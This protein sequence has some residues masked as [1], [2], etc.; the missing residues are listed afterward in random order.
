MH[1][2]RL[3]PLHVVKFTPPVPYSGNVAVL[4]AY[5][6]LPLAVTYMTTL[7]SEA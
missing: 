7:A 1:S 2:V 4:I 3:H 6:A 5:S